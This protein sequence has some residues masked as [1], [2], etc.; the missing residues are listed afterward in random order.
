[1][2][3]EPPTLPPS[4]EPDSIAATLGG[5]YPAIPVGYISFK[6]YLAAGNGGVHR[7]YLD[8]TFWSWL[9]VH[10]EDIKARLDIPANEQD[11]RS[12]IWVQ[13]EA[14][15]TKSR[16]GYAHTMDDEDW[17]ADPA[18]GGLPPRRPPYR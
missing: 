2:S 18:G 12:V 13:R 11:S 15:V 10:A 16:V 3:D 6:G 5:Q 1:M 4:L 17:G 7:L 8:D 9:E 14:K